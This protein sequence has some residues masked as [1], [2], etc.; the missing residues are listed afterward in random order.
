LFER[1]V[2]MNQETWA[3]GKQVLEWFARLNA[4]LEKDVYTEPDKAEILDLLTKLELGRD[5]SPPADLGGNRLGTQLGA[6][7]R[8]V[9]RALVT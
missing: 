5:E 4:L 9:R 1:P 2:A 6:A 8:K 7:P 3:D